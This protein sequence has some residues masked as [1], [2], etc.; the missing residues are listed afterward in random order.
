MWWVNQHTHE[1]AGLKIRDMINHV[2]ADVLLMGTSRCNRHYVPSIIS[3]SIGMSVYNGGI[4]A[5]DNIF[6]HYTLLNLILQRYKPKVICLEVST[7]DFT[8]PQDPFSTVSF[9]APYFGNNEQSDSIFHLAKLYWPYKLFHLYRFNAKA[10]SNIAGLF[11]APQD[12]GKDGYVPSQEPAHHIT[13][14]A[15]TAENLGSTDRQKIRFIQRFIDICNKEN[16]RLIF[17]ISP[18]YTK[19]TTTHY[20]Q[21]KDIANQNGIELLDF[22]SKKLFLDH[23]EYFE[24]RVHLWDKGARLYSI[25]FAGQLKSILYKN[26]YQTYNKK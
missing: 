3:D 18:A 22:H 14:E 13:G 24:D 1:N 6:A 9:F 21:L 17:T 19:I 23:P 12:V 11:I 8:N 25:V 4:D 10:T 7:N 20:K 2:D 26:H 15:T 5:S 16:I